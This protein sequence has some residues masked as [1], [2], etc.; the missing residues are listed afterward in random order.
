MS[1]E[2]TEHL[3]D[4]AALGVCRGQLRHVFRRETRTHKPDPHLPPKARNALTG[5]VDDRIVCQRCRG[6]VLDWDGPF[7]PTLLTVEE[8]LMA[9]IWF[10]EWGDQ[11]GRDDLPLRTQRRHGPAPRRSRRTQLRHGGTR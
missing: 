7:S 3:L 4:I 5:M 1:V 9:W 2:V 8:R 10:A 11:H 6:I